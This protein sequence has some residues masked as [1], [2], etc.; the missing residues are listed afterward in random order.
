MSFSIA[1]LEVACSIEH[2]L[3]WYISSAHFLLLRHHLIY[4]SRDQCVSHAYVLQAQAIVS[5]ELLVAAA[6]AVRPVPAWQPHWARSSTTTS[7]LLEHYS[8]SLASCTSGAASITY[9]SH[10]KAYMA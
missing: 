5:I 6:S 7:S 2:H 10:G 1:H 4:F 3:R 8:S 9:A